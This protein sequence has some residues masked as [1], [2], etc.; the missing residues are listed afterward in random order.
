[1]IYKG[2]N[3]TQALADIKNSNDYEFSTI[4]LLCTSRYLQIFKKPLI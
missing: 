3:V 2:N 1:M 4:I